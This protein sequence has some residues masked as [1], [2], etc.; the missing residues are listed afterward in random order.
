MKSREDFILNEN[1]EEY[2]KYYYAG[3]AMQAICSHYMMFTEKD[4]DKNLDIAV[5]LSKQ[6]IQKLSK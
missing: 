6:L 5:E 1:W 3:L 2:L 4:R